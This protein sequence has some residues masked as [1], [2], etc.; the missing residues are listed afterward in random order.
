MAPVEGAGPRV[1]WAMLMERSVQDNA[2]LSGLSVASYSGGRGYNLLMAPYTR[3][4]IARNKLVERFLAESQDDMDALVMLDCDHVHPPDIIERLVAHG[5][6]RPEVGVV[7]AL[8][9]RRGAP[10]DPCFFIENEEG[11]VDRLAEFGGLHRGTIVGTGA[12]AIRRWVFR[13][14]EEAGYLAPWFRYRYEDGTPEAPSEDMYFGLCC[15]AAGIPH[16]CDTDLEIPHLIASQVDRE[17]WAQYVEDHRDELR[18]V[19]VE[20]GVG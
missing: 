11:G 9:F 12:I 2:V 1:F 8:A 15:Q 14:L 5:N 7:G 3:T 13:R 20:T 10:F 6:Q 4:D 17:S 16:Y 19:E 18:F